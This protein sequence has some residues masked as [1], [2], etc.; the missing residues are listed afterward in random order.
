MRPCH[1]LAIP[2]G[3]ARIKGDTAPGRSAAFPFDPGAAT[4]GRTLTNTCQ[5]KLLGTEESIGFPLGGGGGGETSLAGW[6]AHVRA[7]VPGER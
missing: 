5:T 7:Y 3:E 1:A 6:H 2:T 4:D